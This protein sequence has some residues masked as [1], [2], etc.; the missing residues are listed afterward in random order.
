MM[1]V[2]MVLLCLLLF[3]NTVFANQMYLYK[4]LV[5]QNTLL[6]LNRVFDRLEQT[7]GYEAGITPVVI[8][9]RALCQKQ[10]GFSGCCMCAGK[11]RYDI[12][13]CEMLNIVL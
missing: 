2:I 10:H 12:V 1:K 5:Y 8:C 9:W 3:A 4:S 7:E 11:W 6:S 13:C